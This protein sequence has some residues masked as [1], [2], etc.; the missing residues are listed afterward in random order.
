MITNSGV[1]KWGVKTG[2]DI[3][4]FEDKIITQK[5]LSNLTADESFQALWIGE[6]CEGPV[7]LYLLSTNKDEV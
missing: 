1:G 3:N 2:H 4:G 6:E 7:A 5:E